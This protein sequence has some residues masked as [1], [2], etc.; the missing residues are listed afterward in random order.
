MKKQYPLF[1]QVALTEDLPDY[2]LKEGDIATVVEYYPMPEGDDDGY[3]LEG[4]DVPNVTVEVT[5]SQICSVQQ[6]RKE[7]TLLWKIRQL[8]EPRL[9]QLD[10]YLDDLMKEDA[11]D[12]KSA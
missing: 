11:Q 5:A 12:Q 6:Q 7:E 8:S 4:F 1:S 3:S 2:A 10:R 9:L